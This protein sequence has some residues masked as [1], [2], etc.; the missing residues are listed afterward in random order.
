MKKIFLV[1]HLYLGL[2]GA[3]FLLAI[4]LSGAVI[5]FEPELNRFVH[6]QLATLYPT[7]AVVNCDKV[8]AQ[9]EEQLPGWKVIRFYFPDHSNES[10]YLRP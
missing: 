5:A 3:I 7:S 1:T 8:R 9:V 4:S 6:P 2:A 10:T